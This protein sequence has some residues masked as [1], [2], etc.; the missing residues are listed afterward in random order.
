MSYTLP[1]PSKTSYIIY[2]YFKKYL[3]YCYPMNYSFDLSFL[4]ASRVPCAS[5]SVNTP[6][7]SILN[8]TPLMILR[9]QKNASPPVVPSLNIQLSPLHLYM[10]LLGVSALHYSTG[11]TEG[12]EGFGRWF[13]LMR[14][15]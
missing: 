10:Q 11:S 15:A 2:K 4:N 6:F 1:I 3:R 8:S 13:Q 14:C 7:I 9:N 5:F 12:L